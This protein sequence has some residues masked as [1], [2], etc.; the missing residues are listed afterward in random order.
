MKSAKENDLPEFKVDETY[1]IDHIRVQEG[2]TTSPGYLTESDLISCMEAYEIG[3]DASI[4]Q[5]IKNIIERGY[6]KVDTKKGRALV[7]TNLGMA[8]A[9][10]FCM[11]DSELILPSVRAYIEK[12]CSRV[13]RGEITFQKVID[14]VLNIFKSKFDYFQDHFS[15]IDDFIKK[16]F[17]DKFESE[18]KKAK[19]KGH[20][21]AKDDI[22]FPDDFKSYEHCTVFERKK[23]EKTKE[24]VAKLNCYNCRRAVMKRKL[25]QSKFKAN[26][27]KLILLSRISLLCS[28]L[29]AL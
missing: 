8:L 28:Y 4:P 26:L 22:G 15:V 9:R 13:A 17:V 12:S 20:N 3:T 23:P 25:D 18:S 2:K 29:I 14:H 1:E 6:V 16:E 24:K 19:D 21:P 27:T 11:V 5:H 7:P 10:G